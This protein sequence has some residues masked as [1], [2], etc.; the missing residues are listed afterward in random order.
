VAVFDRVRDQ[1]HKHQL[2]AAG[3]GDDRRQLVADLDHRNEVKEYLEKLTWDG[4]RRID[5]F[6]VD[7]YHAAPTEFNC[8]VGANVLVALV[9]RI[10]EPGCQFDNMMVM[11]GSQGVFKSQ[12]LRALGGQ[13][14]RSLQAGI[15]TDNFVRGM[16][17]AWVIELPELSS[18]TKSAHNAETTKARMSTQV[19]S[20]RPLYK[21]FYRDMPRNSV[22]FGT[23]NEEHFHHDPSSDD[24]RRYWP[25]FVCP[26]GELIELE[27]LKADRDQLFA[28]ALVRYRAGH[29]YWEVPG[30]EQRAL[31]ER[32]RKVNEFQDT[33]AL[34]LANQQ[35]SGRVFDGVTRTFGDAQAS[36]ELTCWNGGDGADDWGTAVTIDRVAKQ[37]LG[38]SSAQLT[39]TKNAHAIGEALRHLGFSKK[40]CRVAGDRDTYLVVWRRTWVHDDGIM[41]VRAPRLERDGSF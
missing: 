17:G 22:T 5:T 32:V 15:D 38:L 11:I 36:I 25:V 33:T 27:L 2:G 10:Y 24:A 31:I 40:R 39:Q 7:I 30:A 9:A 35:D 3:V 34:W 16:H 6:M 28:E 8:A 23:T 18:M 12:S 41:L 19:D 29:K 14:Y 21:N 37:A 20:L 26:N 13:W 4:T 1:V